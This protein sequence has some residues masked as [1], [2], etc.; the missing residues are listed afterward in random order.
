MAIKRFRQDNF[1]NGIH[2]EFF[3]DSAEDLEVIE[4]IY[5]CD[6]GD[7]AL[8]PDGVEYVRHSDDF[9]GDLWV[10]ASGQGDSGGGG[11]VVHEI[12]ETI[13][14]DEEYVLDKTYNEIFA[15]F[16]TGA[17]VV[18]IRK[19]GEACSVIECYAIPGDEFIVISFWEPVQRY[20]A[21]DGDE[22]PRVRV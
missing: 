11:L 2:S 17:P 10:L 19:S 15:S 3:I 6:L 20:F 14:G 9:N 5:D 22:Y 21:F 12:L 8:T 4:D 18:I 16:S 7:K 1:G 13:E